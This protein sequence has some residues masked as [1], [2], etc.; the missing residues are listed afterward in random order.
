MNSAVE[1]GGLGLSSAMLTLGYKLNKNDEIR[2]KN[3]KING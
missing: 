1:K 2:Y 3:R